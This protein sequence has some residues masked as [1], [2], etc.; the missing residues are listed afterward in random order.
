MPR[1]TWLFEETATPEADA[2]V[3][4]VPK[5]RLRDSSLV[6]VAINGHRTWWPTC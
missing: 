6:V 4:P 3:V 1:Y 2:V 5:D